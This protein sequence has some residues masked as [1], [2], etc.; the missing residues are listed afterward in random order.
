MMRPSVTFINH[1]CLLI[2]AGSLCILSDPW[3]SGRVFDNSWGLLQETEIE[4]WETSLRQVTHIYISH[5]HPDHLH[6]PTLK[7]LK[8]LLSND[9]TIIYK[10]Q[11]NSN[12]RE[13]LTGLGYKFLEVEIGNRVDLKPN[14]QFWLFSDA[15][16]T[17]M[18]LKCDNTWILNQNDCLMNSATERKILE[19][20]S[21]IDLHFVQFSIAGWAGNPEERNKLERARR[22]CITR[23][24]D[25]SLRLSSK[26]VVPFA[27]F[28]EFQTSDNQYLNSYRT[29][30][31]DLNNGSKINLQIL[32]Y[33]DEFIWD[34]NESHARSLDNIAKY[35]A[36]TTRS[37]IL[38]IENTPLAKEELIQK[39]HTWL[40]KLRND[41]SPWLLP[42]TVRIGLTT[43]P[44]CLNLNMLSG[45]VNLSPKN[46]K[47]H[48][49]VNPSTLLFLFSQPWGADTLFISGN[50]RIHNGVKFRA[51]MYSYYTLYRF[52][53][54]T[55][56]ARQIVALGGAIVHSLR[57]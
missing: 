3:F 35:T 57:K 48:A 46:K 18:L 43:E 1:A 32:F 41:C 33:G 7:S 19:L 53:R 14:V 8:K 44:L 30:I 13:A 50:I 26:S 15:Y 23:V 2:K 39:A 20:T 5:E 31:S 9:C 56:W 37:P 49:E 11:T 12:V 38:R 6:F 42:F 47:T 55:R 22:D 27:S 36:L 21:S 54:W 28:V 25:E 17:M 51:L 40:E 45:K 16:D 10:K 29:N 34:D 52:P 24:Q 4:K